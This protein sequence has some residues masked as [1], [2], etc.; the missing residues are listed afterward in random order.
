M[1][2]LLITIV[3][4]LFSGVAFVQTPIGSEFTYQGS[5]KF[6]NSPANGLF[7]FEFILYDTELDGTGIGSQPVVIEDVDVLDG[8][9]TVKLDFGTA[10]FYGDKAWLQISVRDGSQAGLFELLL[11]RQEIT[12]APYAIY[13]QYVGFNSVGTN[14]IQN[15]SVDATDLAVSSV[16]TNQIVASE[17]QRRVGSCAVGEYINAVNQDG[18]VICEMD[19]VG[20]GPSSVTSSDIV[21]GTITAIDLANNSVNA[22]KIAAGSIGS[23]EIVS[24]QVQRRISASC[25]H[26]FHL[27]GIN[28]NGSVQCTQSGN[29]LDISINM[30]DPFG[31]YHSVAIRE[32]SGLPIIS[33]W[34]P[35]S[36]DLKV[37]SCNDSRC[38]TGAT[39]VLDS[40]G[41]V[42]LY[43]SIAIKSDGNAIISYYDETNTNL[44]VYSCS[45]NNCTS[46]NAYVVD[47]LGDVGQ[48]T[49]IAVRSNGNAIISYYDVGNGDLNLYS[50][51]NS[52]CSNGSAYL[53]D[54]TDDVGRYTSIAVDS[55]DIARIAYQDWTNKNLKVFSCA[56][57]T[58]NTGTAY[59]LDSANDTGFHTSV[60]IKSD[61]KAVISYHNATQSDLKL[62]NCANTSCSAGTAYTLDSASDTGFD[63]AI[64]IK[65]NGNPIV[66]YIDFTFQDLKIYSCSNS[67][68]S[69]GISTS[70]YSIA[71]S[72]GN[73]LAMALR[74]DGTPLISFVK[75]TN[76]VLSVYSC[77][78]VDC[79]R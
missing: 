51:D 25:S 73:Y 8:L 41:D 62:F 39:T 72:V 56:N 47:N 79:R 28:E 36:K 29:A 75:G 63:T 70:A 5:L 38:Q 52:N 67:N 54:G 31:W 58:C 76:N 43:P 6:N 60:A 64:A 71:G 66:S 7:D 20:G 37:V 45:N 24:S 77:G 17:V 3:L 19:Q 11:P 68:C 13:A 48:Y 50:C 35:S 53:L 10:A 26:G 32:P 69:K 1:K 14:E 59:T 12:S 74:S 21:D 65:P 27:T 34:S 2:Y 46:G 33:Y 49:S 61:D 40:T 57:T 30:N 18:S 55:N 9:F 23:N 4:F 16:G 22:A 44:K 15:G 78:D 42:G